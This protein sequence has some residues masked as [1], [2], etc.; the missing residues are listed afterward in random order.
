MA[1]WST[2][3][4][5]DQT[6]YHVWL[7][8]PQLCSIHISCILHA[9]SIRRQFLHF[10]RILLRCSWSNIVLGLTTKM[11]TCPTVWNHRCLKHKTS[12]EDV[13]CS[14]TYRRSLDKKDS[15]QTA[16]DSNKVCIPASLE[17][18]L[19][20]VAAILTHCYQM[21]MKLLNKTPGYLTPSKAYWTTFV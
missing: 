9:Y 5:N 21:R 1:L 2:Q 14:S 11:Q 12:K 10:I 15:S 18:H 8:D 16:S 3:S 13:C 19:I 17:T 4:D 6:L 20:K 7:E